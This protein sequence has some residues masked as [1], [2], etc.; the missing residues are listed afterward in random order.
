[1]VNN[2]SS[3]YMVFKGTL[4]EMLT[5]V[6]SVNNQCFSVMMDYKS[7]NMPEERAARY[8]AVS[9]LEY[10]CY[11]LKVTGSS[12]RTTDDKLYQLNSALKIK[13][14]WIELNNSFLITDV[15]LTSGQNGCR[16]ALNLEK[17]A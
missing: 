17:M 8:A 5:K 9:E 2:E 4:N 3:V 14:P 1:M 12:F 15:D 11:D 6:E 10:D 13:D 7:P 16:A